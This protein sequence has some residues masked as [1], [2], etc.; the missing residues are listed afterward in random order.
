[1]ASHAQDKTIIIE[2]EDGHLSNNKRLIFIHEEAY[3]T[4]IG[5]L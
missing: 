1:M 3:K 5:F 4:L 2:Q